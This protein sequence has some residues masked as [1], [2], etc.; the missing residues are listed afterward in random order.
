MPMPG[1]RVA[2][3]RRQ[4]VKDVPG[5]CSFCRSRCGSINS[6]VAGKLVSVRPF[7]DHPTGKAL[8]PKGRAAPELVHSARRLTKPLIRTRPK[9]D[10]DP[11]F[12]E[13]DWDQ[14]LDI[15]AEKLAHIAQ[16]S[17]PEAVAFSFSSPSATSISDAIPWLERFVW[18][19]GSPNICWAT[20]L[21]N[22]HK[23]HNH[24]LTLGSGLPV[25]DY[26]NS[27]LI[28]LWGHNP[29]KVWL[30]QA[31][32]I[33]K[34]QQ[35]GADLVL[36]DPRKTGMAARAAQWL[37]V[38]PGTD[39]ALALA[40]IKLLIDQNG[41]DSAFVR[42]WSNA[43]FLVRSDNGALLRGSDI[44]ATPTDA[45]IAR[46]LPTGELIAV[47]TDRTNDSALSDLF[48][49][50]AECE[51]TLKGG[52]RVR[53]R[54]AFAHLRRAAAD[55]TPERTAGICRVDA[56]EIRKLAQRIISAKRISYYCWTGVGQHANAAQTD[57]AIACLFALTGQY[58]MPGGNVLWPSIPVAKISDYSMLPP[59]QAR[60]SLGFGPRPLG[61]AS[62]G[63]VT[64]GEI[65]Q[66]ILEEQPYK[67]RALVSFGSNVLSS[68]PDPTRGRAALEKLEFQVHCDMFQNPSAMTADIILPVNSAWERDGLRLGFEISLQAQQR[69]QLRPAM[70]TAQGKSRS[71]FDIVAGLAERLGFGDEFAHGDWDAAHDAFLQP[72]GLSVAQLRQNPEGMAYPLDHGFRSY[73]K[74]RG[75]G[76][77]VGFS[78][79]S[80]R[81]EIYSSL[82]Q[83]IGQP[84]VPSFVPPEEPDI[85]HPL[86]LTTAKS[87]YYCHTQHRGLNGL[88]RKSPRPRIDI[89]P[90]TAAERD[91]VEYGEVEVLRGSRKVTME[92][93]FDSD[94]HPDVV[95]AEYGWWQS[96][97]DLGEPGYEIGGANDANYNSLATFD[98]IDPVTGAPAV[99][100]LCCNIRASGDAANSPWIG[101]R[102][103]RVV[104]KTDET[105][106]VVTLQL[107]AADGHPL[108]RF[109]AGQF[110][111]VR[112]PGGE[113][114]AVSRSYSLTGTPCASPASYSIAVRRISDGRL[115]S[116]LCSLSVGDQVEATRPDGRFTLPVENE[117]PVVL[118]ASG[119][120][121]TPFMS[122]LEQLVANDGPEIWLY[123]GSRN[124]TQH[125]FR[126]RITEIAIGNPALTVRNFYSR[127]GAADTEP[128]DF[129]R[130]TVDRIDQELIERKARF[131][132]CGPGEMITDF[133]KGLIARGVPDF[134]IFFERFSSP[135]RSPLVG[136]TQCD[137]HFRR[138]N[139]TI[140]WSP[141][142]G[143]ILELADRNRISLPAGCRTGQCES[144]SVSLVSGEVA[145]HTDISEEP[146][147][148][149]LTCQAYPITDIVLDA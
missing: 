144:C 148:G 29:E 115:S 81:I 8:C 83:T 147:D 73:A 48:D 138:Q 12:T 55:F 96:A 108:A 40:L 38:R 127:P 74:C 27:D 41:Y 18:K 30:A 52:H 64:G 128:H 7:P 100:S 77:V 68:H 126:R 80:R 63:W 93:R 105:P 131:Y 50:E 17:G 109:R 34:A 92:A 59:E 36:V 32:A 19:Y 51:V 15:I 133:R 107:E 72:S 47:D 5:F 16:E 14:A 31:D 134:E 130:L 87:G 121:I 46:N 102:K 61:P 11:G 3:P 146:S 44:E 124:L 88:R 132:I 75:D 149:C 62:G 112:L 125:A 91:I 65:Y 135:R 137:I 33:A 94:L 120:G 106:D 24:K 82:L 114:E 103:F 22:W 110:L 129:G 54:T 104:G 10:R 117:F 58:D 21:C 71:D 67:L 9:G 66:A 37:R 25:P 56:D 97:P 84:P 86:T 122:L 78:T 26:E 85:H 145:Y 28:V 143:S 95:V 57:R 90:T 140:T 70:V 79:P 39:G 20:E 60:K 6:I 2:P 89:H 113:D 13:I 98:R 101:Y 45:F 119:I 43:P 111:T 53:C 99:R 4:E 123:Y 49:L 1:E 76:S 136:A 142:D 141:R 139:K 118:I 23:D 116:R 42:Q 35:R 69:A